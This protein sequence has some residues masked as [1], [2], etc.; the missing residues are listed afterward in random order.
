MGCPITVIK[1]TTLS[2]KKAKEKS[3]IKKY[4]IKKEMKVIQVIQVIRK[5]K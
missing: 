2:N 3:E 1:Q 4:Q 5:N